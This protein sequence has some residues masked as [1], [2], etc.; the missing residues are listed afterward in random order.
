M[1][2]LEEGEGSERIY[3]H[4]DTIMTLSALLVSSQHPSIKYKLKPLPI[5]LG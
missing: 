1:Y 2:C 3:L 4:N 5:P